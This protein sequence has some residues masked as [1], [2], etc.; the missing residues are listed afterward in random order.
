MLGP[1]F[2]NNLS[3]SHFKSNV[4]QIA[5]MGLFVCRFIRVHES[6]LY[7]IY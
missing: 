5:I 1:E 3:L 4:H 2:F 7:C 6:P